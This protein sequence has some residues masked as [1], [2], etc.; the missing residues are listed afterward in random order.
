MQETLEYQIKN[1]T[2]DLNRIILNLIGNIIFTR[3][4]KLGT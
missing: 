3:A 4:W 2:A 1:E